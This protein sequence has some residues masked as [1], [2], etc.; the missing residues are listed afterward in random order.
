MAVENDGR[1][2][3]INQLTDGS[4]YEKRRKEEG[5]SVHVRVRRAKT[6]TRSVGEPM[7]ILLIRKRG[8]EA[9]RL[10]ACLP[11][12]QHASLP[13]GEGSVRFEPSRNRVYIAIA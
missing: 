5:P 7:A 6:T 8:G 13:A 4:N 1:N 10:A 12:S 3:A 11:A 2:P 9:G